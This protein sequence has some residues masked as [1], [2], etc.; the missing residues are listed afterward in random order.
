MLLIRIKVFTLLFLVIG[1]HTL[2]GQFNPGE[3]GHDQDICYRSAPSTLIFTLLPSGG[4][5]PYSFRW[6]R[7]NDGGNTWNDISGISA[8]RQVFSPPLLSRTAS[9]RC[10]VTDSESSSGTTNAVTI[11]VADDI[12]AG[13]VSDNQTIY[14]GTTPQRIIELASPSGGGGSF[15]F[16]WQSSTDG[17]SWTDIDGATQIG[18]QPHSLMEISWFRRIV[19]DESCG[20]TAS[21]SISINTI[22]ITL[23]TT[24]SPDASFSY[25]RCDLGTEFEVLADGVITRVRLYSNVNEGGVHQIRL[26]RLSS[27]LEYEILLGPIEWDLIPGYAGWRE[28]ELPAPVYVEA[29]Q[30]F[31]ISITNSSED[32]WWVQGNDFVPDTTNDYIRYLGGLLTTNLGSVPSD[33]WDGSGFFRDIVFVPFSPGSA[34]A[35]QSVCYNTVPAS[36][37]ETIGPSG[38]SGEY[39]FQW[40]I[41]ADGTTWINIDGADSPDFSPQAL[42]A[43]SY[44]RRAVTSEAFTGFTT[45]VFVNV[46]PLFNTAQ[47]F[48]DITI[49]QNSGTNLGLRLSG[50]TPPYSIEYN[51]NT[52]PQNPILADSDS[53]EFYTGQ[54]HAGSYLYTLTSVT[55]NIGCEVQSL[56]TPIT[57]TAEGNYLGEGTNKALVMINSESIF[58]TEYELYIK[59]YIDWFGIPYETC[60]VVTDELPPLNNFAIIILGHNFLFEDNYPISEIEI[61]VS[62]GTGLY[63]F[64][65]HL[66]D[67]QSAFNAPGAIHPQ[68]TS[69]QIDF[70]T[71]HYITQLHEVDQYNPANNLA[72]LKYIGEV[73]QTLTVDETYFS[74]TG[75]NTVTLATISEGVNTEP[76]LQV[77]EFGNGRV[78]KWSSYDW[79]FDHVF[80]PVRGMD[81]LIWRGIIWAARKPFVMQGLPPMITMRVDDVDGVGSQY[82]QDLEWLQICN[83]F[84]LIPWVGIFTRTNSVSFY[85]ILRDL[86][87]NNLATASPHSFTIDDLI[88]FNYDDN[89]DFSAPD[90]VRKVRDI[91]NANNLQMSNYLVPHHYLLTSDAL[92]E[93]RSM[94]IEFIGTN[95]PCDRIPGLDYPGEWLM[96]GPFRI[97]RSGFGW[98]GT[99]KFYADSV[100][101]SGNDFFICL[102]EISDDGPPGFGYEWYPNIGTNDDVI[103]RGIRHLRRALDGMELPVLFT[104]EYYIDLSAE[105][106]RQILSEITNVIS[107]YNPEY[108]STDDALQYVRARK[109]IKLEDVI[110]DDGLISISCS[111]VNDTETKCYLFL[112]DGNQI[113]FRLITLPIVNNNEEPVTIGIME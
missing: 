17:F 69:S 77:T 100:N 22:P 81:D 34:G 107:V 106:W 32:Q 68:V 85:G 53:S 93:I 60:D 110:S 95:I 61:A 11:N 88:Y 48:S 84:G 7:S 37:N 29:G 63:S 51:R 16:Q 108:I 14:A 89:P 103:A 44:F 3:I 90:S 30:D 78:V 71:D 67:Y 6:Q 38:A 58:F 104:H 57:V 35:S 50:G 59:P 112:E 70:M 8:S 45:P 52:V 80:G 24:E 9:F 2:H 41:S 99:P 40:Q 56:G 83:E 75:V 19:I 94:G 25:L 82:M 36:L 10:Y 86:I 73:Q 76:L 55:D 47:L 96:A 109:N 28:F 102:T 98:Q 92:A 13:I 91:F 33:P 46:S 66:F 54:L 62:S 101:W 74:L 64:D 87:D 105:N 1:C 12:F 49:Y 39:E 79:M 15:T 5:A 20:S 97:G 43:S 21:N 18:Y 111:G 31:I 72:T 113:S 27:E 26:W 42:S 23:Y 65:D 4:E